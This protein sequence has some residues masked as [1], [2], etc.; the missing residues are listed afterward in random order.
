MLSVSE[1]GGEFL[2][3]LLRQVIEK[4]PNEYISTD[5]MSAILSYSAALAK[6]FGVHTSCSNAKAI[7]MRNE[8]FLSRFY[9]I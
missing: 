9:A 4:Y 3:K 7:D 2:R 1:K 6:R 8:D 5:L